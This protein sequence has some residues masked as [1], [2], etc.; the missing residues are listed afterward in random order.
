MRRVLRKRLAGAGTAALLLSI[1]VLA[2]ATAAGASLEQRLDAAVSR[3]GI[4]GSSSVY[5]WDQATREVIYSRGASRFVTPASTMKLLTSAAALARF[6]PDHRFTTQVALRGRQD[7]ARFDGDVWL[8]GGGDPS[9]STFGFSRDNYDGAGTNLAMLVR[10]LRELGITEVSG[11]VRVDDELF[12]NLRWAP[13]WKPAFR[14]EETGALGALTV[15]QS[16]TG[17]WVGS[18]SARSPDVHAGLTFRELLRRQG[19][20]VR[21]GVAGGAVPTSATVVGQVESRPLEVLLQHMNQSSDNFYAEILLKDIGADRFGPD[22]STADGAR[23]ARNELQEL[24][25]AMRGVRWADG[26]GL[27]YGNRVTARHVGHVLGMGAQT[28]WGESWIQSFAQSGTSGTLRRRMTRS[29]F[30]GRVYAK[31]GTLRHASG[32]A[33]FSHRQGSERRFGFVVLTY[34]ASGGQVSYTAA[35]GLQDRVAMILVR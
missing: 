10:P 33:G 14:F 15:N 24:G 29:P 8:I 26:S 7:G 4:A 3:S 32:L 23:A 21:S 12:D 19:I 28:E 13:G 25:V 11:R 35:R 31:T 16:L 9:L 5:A 1:A 22:A 6:G 20:V 34:R 27:A 30:R 18:R 2:P 17:R